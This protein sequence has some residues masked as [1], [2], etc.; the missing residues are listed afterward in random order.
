MGH[1]FTAEI[2]VYYILISV[3]QTVQLSGAEWLT[4]KM[5]IFLST[6]SQDYEINLESIS[7]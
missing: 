7:T 6:S 1:K 3:R 4:Q 2:I 5:Y